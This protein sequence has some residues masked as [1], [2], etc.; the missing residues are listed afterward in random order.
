[1]SKKSAHLYINPKGYPVTRHSYSGSSLFN[2]CNR[3]YFLERVAGYKEKALDRAAAMIFGKV[4]EN[5]VTFYHTHGKQVET[6]W[7]YFCAEWDNFKEQELDYSK[8]LTSWEDAWRTGNE[9]LRLYALRYPSL[10][11]E[12]TGEDNFQ[13]LRTWEV[14]PNTKLAGIELYSYLDILA[15]LKPG[16]FPEAKTDKV[17]LDMKVS[18]ADCP[19]LVSLDP[20][21]R[22]YSMVTKYP[23]VGFLWLGVE[24][25][26]LEKGTEVTL[27]TDAGPLKKGSVTL[28]LST[29]FKEIPTKPESVYLSPTREIFKEF[30]KMPG[31]KVAEKEAKLNFIQKHGILTPVCDITRQTVEVRLAVINDESREDIKK[32]IEH[33][34]IR[35]HNASEE[36]FWPMQSGVRYPHNKCTSCPMRGICT[37]ND[38]LRDELLERSQEMVF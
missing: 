17:I 29:D 21:L 37:G 9:L 20:Q 27:L 13:V 38:E 2:D 3:R 30:E 16:R 7:A 18:A 28:I 11:F 1:M 36:D 12:I 26:V 23:V 32:Q 25:R 8:K 31:R 6:A 15:K 34:V 10:P 35:I 22:T 33:D 24:S 5:T 14:F 19:K 4:M